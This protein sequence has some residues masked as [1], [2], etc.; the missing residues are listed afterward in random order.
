MRIPEARKDKMKR[1]IKYYE[2]DYPETEPEWV[3]IFHQLAYY[4]KNKIDYAFDSNQYYICEECGELVS[5]G[6]EELHCC[7]CDIPVERTKIDYLVN[8]GE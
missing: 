8:G 7:Y 5:R 2:L 1:Y 6:N 4:I 3:E